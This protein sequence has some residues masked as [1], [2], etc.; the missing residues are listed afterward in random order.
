MLWNYRYIIKAHDTRALYRQFNRIAGVNTKR[1]QINVGEWL[2]PLSPQYNATLAEA[3]FHYSPRAASNERFE[4]CIATKEMNEAA[5]K[6]PYQ[7]QITV[8]GTLGVC[9]SKLLLFIVM[10]VDEKKGVPLAFLMCSAPSK[11]KQTS[12][13]YDTEILTKLM[14]KWRSD[15]KKMH[16]GKAFEVLVAITDTDLKERG[17]LL[18]VFPH[19]WLLICKFHLRQSW[20][21]PRNKAIKGKPP[22]FVDTK[23][24][25]ARLESEL[26]QTTEYSTA[27]LLLRKEREILKAMSASS[28]A[29][30]RGLE[31]LEYLEGYWLNES[32]WRSWSDSGRRMAAHLLSCAFKGVLPT[33]NHL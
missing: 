18:A 32:L 6:Y 17:A 22:S 30:S 26:I 27:C 28:S 23:G 4:V 7:S 33:T 8:D 24:R 11:N 21:N 5:W 16:S 29:A 2:D 13:G 19:I 9:D 15:L 10:G 1:P 14:R 3:I 31:H 20:R 12:S 25:M